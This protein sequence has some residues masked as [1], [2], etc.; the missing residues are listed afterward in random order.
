MDV[1]INTVTNAPSGAGCKHARIQGTVNGVTPV[2]II[3]PVADFVGEPD[4][5]I[6]A[7]KAVIRSKLKE[8]GISTPAAARTFLQNLTVKL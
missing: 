4:D 6:E 5:P 3:F 1:L 8:A 7:F 2:D